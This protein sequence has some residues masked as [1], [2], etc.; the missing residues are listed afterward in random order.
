MVAAEAL[1]GS[2]AGTPALNITSA[3]ARPSRMLSGNSLAI[4]RIT[5]LIRQVA[6]HDSTVLLLGESGTGKEV[7]ARTIH[8]LSPRRNRPFVAVNCGAIPADLLESELF[9]HEKGSFT[10]AISARKGRFEIAEGGTLFLDEI[11]DMSV[12][13]QVKLL[14][15]LQERVFERVGNHVT[16]PCNVRIIAATHRNLEDSITR[17]SFREDLYHRLNVFPIDMPPLRERLEDLP[18]LVREFIAQN[19]AEGRGRVQ[20]SAAALG[21]LARHP[22]T[23]NVRELAN[24]IERLSIVCAGR[25]VEVRDLPPRYQPADFDP[26]PL[27]E[28]GGLAAMTE[29]DDA[30]IVGS[31]PLTDAAVIEVLESGVPGVASDTTEPAAAAAADAGTMLAAAA[32]RLPAAGLDLRAFLTSIERRLIEQALESAN[33]TVAHAARLLNLRRTTLVEKL[34]KLGIGTAESLTED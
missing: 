31:E 24:L 2:F 33:G 4:R 1:A 9:G 8:E 27:E 25:V 19:A 16:V 17:G 18:M 10:G 13:M 5:T 26:A 30:I 21:A 15:V 3:E 29:S 7:A 14:R 32:V 11:G 23:G 6:A 20:L 34:R 28:S 22:W 12:A